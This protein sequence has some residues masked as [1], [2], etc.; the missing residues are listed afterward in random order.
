MR[1][2]IA[3]MRTEYAS[4]TAKDWANWSL[5]LG[6]TVALLVWILSQSL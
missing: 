6:V 4:M 2:F 5:T 3:D 1:D